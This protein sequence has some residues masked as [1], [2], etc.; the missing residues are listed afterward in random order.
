VFGVRSEVNN[1][2]FHHAAHALHQPGKAAAPML[3][4]WRF[5]HQPQ[6]FLDQIPE[7]AAAQRS[8]RLGA[9]V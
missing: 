8:F 4:G 9:A 5:E 7:L 1:A 6:A 3:G 2:R